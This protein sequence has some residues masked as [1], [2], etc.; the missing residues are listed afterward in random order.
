MT[1]GRLV[2]VRHGVTDWNRAGRFQGHLDPPLAEDGRTEARL[3]AARL[4]A[5]PAGERPTRVIASSLARAAETGLIVA[6]SLGIPFAT[7]QRL[8]EIGQGE[9]EGR[10]HAELERDDAERYAAWRALPDARPPGAEDLDVVTRRASSAV[11]EALATG[12]VTCVVTH[13]G[14]LRVLAGKLLALRARGWDLDADNCSLSVLV[15]D[16]EVGWRLERWNDVHHLLGVLRT[17]VDEDEGHPLA[18]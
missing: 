13:G 6:D 14:V 9:W 10:T 3:L 5:Q 2:L 11:D 15:Q 8:I 16:E 1:A 17:H 12:G 7:D 4:A 18:L